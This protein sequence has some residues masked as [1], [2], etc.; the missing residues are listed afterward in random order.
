MVELKQVYICSKCGCRDIDIRMVHDVDT[1]VP[2]P[3][4]ISQAKCSASKYNY[5]SYCLKAIQS[6]KPGESILIKDRSGTTVRGWIMCLA[7]DIVRAQRI[8]ENK[9]PRNPF[10]VRWKYKELMKDNYRIEQVAHF[11]HRVWKT[12]EI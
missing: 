8:K 3:A 9:S 7:R 6:M 2:V 5:K 4:P 10:S 1:D 12:K 11:E